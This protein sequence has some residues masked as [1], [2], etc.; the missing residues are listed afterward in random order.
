MPKP[1]IT[2]GITAFNAEDTIG[3]AIHSALVQDWTPLEVVVVDDASCDATVAR[4]EEFAA[5]SPIVR[6]VR[7]SANGGAATARNTILDVA[8]GEFVAFFDDDDESHPSRISAQ[9][10]RIEEYEKTLLAPVPVLCHTARRQHFPDG[11]V[12]IEATMGADRNGSPLFGPAVA[13]RILR[14]D[15]VPG[16]YGSCATC[17]Q[18]ARL[19]TYRQVGGFDPAF[20]RSDDTDLIVRLAIAGAHFVGIAEPLVEQRKALTS[21]KSLEI[22]LE[23]H[24]ALLR[25]HRVLFRDPG[26]LAFA[27]S[28]LRL[29][30]LLLRGR[31]APFVSGLARL[32]LRRPISVLKRMAW[33]LPLTGSRVAIAKLHRSME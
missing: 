27:E 6:I 15:P 10:A 2:V 20:R 24:L 31:R 29:K 4:I 9:F 32:G 26:D 30:Y 19:S 3:R 22:D 23:F 8:R 1:L 11:S 7:H 13:R 25:K 21:D 14:G 33:S 16:G 5:R 18:M 17:S 28:W 12:R